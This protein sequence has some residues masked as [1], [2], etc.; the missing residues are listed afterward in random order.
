MYCTYLVPIGSIYELVYTH[1][2]I[3]HHLSKSIEIYYNDKFNTRE[4]TYRNRLTPSKCKSAEMY[5]MNV[6][7]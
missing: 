6:T 7:F 2:N 5:E 1:T 3:K 4:K